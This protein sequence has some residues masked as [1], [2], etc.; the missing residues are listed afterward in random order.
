[1]VAKSPAAADAGEDTVQYRLLET[2][3]AYAMEKLNQSCAV[4]RAALGNDVF[5]GDGSEC[6]DGLGSGYMI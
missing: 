4:G 3:R 1:L 2:T 5:P 6:R